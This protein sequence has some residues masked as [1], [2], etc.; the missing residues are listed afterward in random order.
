MWSDPFRN[1]KY[2]NLIF[3]IGSLVLMQTL[4]APT[5]WSKTHKT[6]L[7][8]SPWQSSSHLSSSITVS[9]ALMSGP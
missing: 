1:D 8:Y 3:F 5:V 9:V 7:K 6:T 2:H 4:R